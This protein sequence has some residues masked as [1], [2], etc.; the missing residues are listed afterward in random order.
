MQVLLLRLL[1]L[2]V[3]LPWVLLRQGLDIADALQKYTILTI[4]DGLVSQIPSLC[5]SLATG[6]LVTKASKEADFSDILVRQLF[7]I[8]K[9]LYVVGATM[10]ILSLTPLTTWL[11]ILYGIM[12]IVVGYTIDKKTAIAG[13]EEEVDT[14]ETQAEEIRR[15][16]NVASLLTG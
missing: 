1:T 16:E 15:P 14:D 9:V 7:G 2:S 11:F 5:I 8:P 3:V 10:I 13:I 4:G 6:I 12:F